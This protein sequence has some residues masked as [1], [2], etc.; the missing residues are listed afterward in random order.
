MTKPGEGI[1]SQSPNRVEARGID[2]A[3]TKALR[4]TG[5]A[6][7]KPGEGIASQSPNRVEARGIEPRSE[8]HLLALL[9]T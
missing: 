6:M 4:S 9:R 3:C 5:G 1:A 2:P 8:N 7:T